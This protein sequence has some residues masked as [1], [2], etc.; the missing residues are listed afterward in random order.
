MFVILSQMLM[1]ALGK[2][3]GEGSVPAGGGGRS[4]REQVR[5]EWPLGGETRQHLPDD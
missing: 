4:H 5:R 3:G 2:Q 1:E